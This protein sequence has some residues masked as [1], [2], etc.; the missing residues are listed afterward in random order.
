M[1]TA[2]AQHIRRNEPDKDESSQ[3]EQ[4][5][6]MLHQFNEPNLSRIETATGGTKRTF[7]HIAK[8]IRNRDNLSLHKLLNPLEHRYG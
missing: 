4:V 2:S 8:V 6:L 1:R 3:L 7:G 5:E